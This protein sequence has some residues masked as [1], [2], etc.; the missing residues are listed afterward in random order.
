M[1]VGALTLV[2]A[3]GSA[4]QAGGAGSDGT[5]SGDP[6]GQI[7]GGRPT[8]IVV[9]TPVGDSTVYGSGRGSGG[10]WTCRYF[11]V[12]SQGGSSDAGPQ[13]DLG[14]GAISPQRGDLVA[15]Q[16]RDQDGQLVRDDLL[17]FDPAD[18]IGG[19]FAAERAAEQALSQLTL[20]VPVM[21]MSPP[22][23]QLVGVATWLWLDGGWGPLST[24]ATI[25]AV[26]STV[27]ATPRAVV[28]DLGDGTSV[29]CAGPGVAYAADATPADACTATFVDSS[30]DRPGGTQ[31]VTATVSYEVGWSANTGEGDD[32]GELT[33]VGAVD[34]RV[35]EVQAV[36]N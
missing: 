27:T 17:F 26:T 30:A 4:S 12:R 7:R 23:D 25:G 35:V 13:A 9:S 11:G 21:S 29:A 33:A 31:R 10:G 15:L 1:V 16:C 20:P 18:P 34:V 24:S 8:A 36:I 19:L 5:G 6:S 3:L 32:L 2:S 14:G 28:W 22:G